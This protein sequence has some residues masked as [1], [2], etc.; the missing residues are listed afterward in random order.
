MLED[1][2]LNKEKTYLIT[3]IDDKKLKFIEE[4]FNSNQIDFKRIDD[5]TE[6]KKAEHI[7]LLCLMDMALKI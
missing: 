5:V 1:I 6:I 7:Y 4:T 3:H 2:K